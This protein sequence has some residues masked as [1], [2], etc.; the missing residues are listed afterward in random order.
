MAVVV[1]E[2]SVESK[3]LISPDASAYC[4]ARKRVPLSVFVSI[5]HKVGQCLQHKAKDQHLWH[6][7]RIR[8]VDGSSCSMPDTPELQSAFGQPDGQKKGCG[9]TV[10]RIVAMFCWA[11]GAALDVAIGPYR[12]SELSLVGQLWGRRIGRQVLLHLC[13]SGRIACAGLRRGFSPSWGPFAYD[14]LPQ[15]KTAG[16]RGPTD[17]VGSPQD[18]PERSVPRAVDVTAGAFDRSGASV[19][20]ECSWLPQPDNHSG[21]DTVGSGGL[22]V[23]GDCGLVW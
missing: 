4:Q 8:L 6:G 19:L 11:T 18:L 21:H 2:E 3:R 10:A 15:G 5:L 12:S 16:S 7:H 14:G 20:Y 23:G 9:F 17:D 13:D 1:A 22:S